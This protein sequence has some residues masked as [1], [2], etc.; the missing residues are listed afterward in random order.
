M[1]FF[2]LEVLKGK[3]TKSKGIMSHLELSNDMFLGCND[4]QKIQKTCHAIEKNYNFVTNIYV[5]PL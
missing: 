5:V 3:S 2:D 1:S 4:S